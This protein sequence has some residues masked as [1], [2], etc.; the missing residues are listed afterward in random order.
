MSWRLVACVSALCFLLRV[1]SP[2]LLRGRDLP[3]GLERRLEGAVTPL[4][5]ALFAIQLFADAGAWR[6]DDRAVGVAAAAGVYWLRRSLPLTLLAA[7]LATA[8]VR[9]L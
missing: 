8:A 4:V 3:A 7:A 6:V 2:L 9:L 1:A 5:G